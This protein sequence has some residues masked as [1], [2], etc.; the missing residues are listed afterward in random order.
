MWRRL[1]RDED[2]W[3][4]LAEALDSPEGDRLYAVQRKEARRRREER[5]AAEREAQRPMCA[6]CGA[7][8]TDERWK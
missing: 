2:Q 6:G 7:K 4:T 1:G 3:Q 8:F 5:E